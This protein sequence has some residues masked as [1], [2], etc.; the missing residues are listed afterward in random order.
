MILGMTADTLTLFMF[1]QLG[2]GTATNGV[3][4]I[5]VVGL[6]GSVEYLDLGSVR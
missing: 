4:P 5:T 2:D 6:N 1:L 3:V